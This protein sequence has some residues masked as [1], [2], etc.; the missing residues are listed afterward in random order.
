ML[1]LPLKGINNLGDKIGIN[2]NIFIGNLS[3]N[4]AEADLRYAFEVFGQVVSV[5]VI[6]DK[7]SG[8]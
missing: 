1:G 3:Y 7:Q 6:K 2:M 8:R 4:V 5:T